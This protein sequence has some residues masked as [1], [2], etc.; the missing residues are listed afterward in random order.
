MA[1]N[2]FIFKYFQAVNVLH[3]AN[4]FTCTAGCENKMH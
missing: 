1:R 3:I 2:I 4:L